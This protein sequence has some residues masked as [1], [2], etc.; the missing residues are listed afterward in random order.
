MKPLVT[1]FAIATTLLSVSACKTS[2]S[3]S[4]TDAV[5]APSDL[6]AEPLDGGAHLTWHDNS[7]NEAEFMIER[8]M[9][10]ED[11]KNVGMVPFNTTSFH[12]PN[13]MDG[14]TYMYRVMAMPKSG[15]HGSYSNEAKC[16]G[17]HGSGAAGESSPHDAHHPAASGAGGA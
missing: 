1:T 14:A 12:D 9:E 13:L 5:K 10:G 17:Q 3:S 16:V 15:D 4:S 7:E 6:T 8:K 11:W 2:D